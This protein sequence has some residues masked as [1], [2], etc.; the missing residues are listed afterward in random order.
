MEPKTKILLA[1]LGAAALALSGCSGGGGGGGSPSSPTPPDL[2]GVWAGAWQGT[3][4]SLGLVSGT[5][6]VTITQGA[7]SA[8]GPG[9]LLGDIDCMDGNMQSNPGTQTSVTGFLTRPGC[10]QVNWTLTALNVASG[11]ASGSWNNAGTGGSGTLS[12][13]RIARLSGPLVRFVSPPGGKAGT[14]ATVVGTG[15]APLSGANAVLFGGMPQ[16]PLSSDATRI[17]ARVPGG[18]A[19]GAV[20][21]STSTGVALSPYPFNIDVISPPLSLGNS[22]SPGVAPA[23]LA[24]SPDGRKFYIA[25]RS[26]NTVR[27]VRA[28]TLANLVSRTV[29]GG[30]PRSVVASPDGKRVYVAAVGVGVLVMDAANLTQVNAVPLTINDGGRDNPQGIAISPDGHTLLVSDGTAGGNVTVFTISGDTLTAG[31]P[32]SMPGG[33]VAA[34]GVAFAPDGAQAYVAAAETAGAVGTLRVFNPANGALIGSLSV[35]VGLLPTGIAVSPDG[36]LVFVTNKNGNTVSIYNSVT[37]A[38]V[39]TVAV[40]TQPTGVAF[41][42]DGT[43]VFVAN[44]GSNNVSVIDTS[45]FTAS[46][47]AGLQGPLAIAMNPQG[48]TA[49]VSQLT[50]GS[51]RE[52]GG[53][54]TLTVLR[55]GSGIGDVTSSPAGILCGTSCQAQ[56]VSGTSIS[57]TA[58][59]DSRS[60]FSGWSGDAGCGSTVTLN[61]NMTC[62]ATFASALPPPSQQQ[63]P[64]GS[65]FIAT[66][67]Y[68]SEWAPEVQMLREFRGRHLMTNAPGRA[69]VRWYYRYSPP[70]AELIRPHES[71]RATVRVALWPVVW[72]IS[73]PTSALWIFVLLGVLGWSL[74][75]RALRLARAGST[76]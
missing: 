24:V 21:V 38:V 12:G 30:S 4:P 73:H 26:N 27:A 10:P 57:L 74:R 48:T 31:L 16:T 36:N 40:G 32:H 9:T 67:A 29:A 33:T 49:Y 19:T 7:T 13:A 25:D 34:L 41:A 70:L 39:N 60:S 43:R 22:S 69:F 28:S 44:T 17:I 45:S 6:E 72:S 35:D 50:L 55:A 42:P 54:R 37:Q 11:A 63:P 66:A 8:A 47:F 1:A 18:A 14:V 2:S 61:T 65:C 20:Q 75:R 62:R 58:T 51:V 3:D 46:L 53:M 59:P 68:G 71:A 64:P 15:L 23:A 76:Q 5:W 52:I 56:F